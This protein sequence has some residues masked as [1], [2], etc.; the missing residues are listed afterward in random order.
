MVYEQRTYRNLVKAD[1]LIKFEVIDQETDLLILAEKDL[2]EKAL[3]LVKQY[4]QELETFMKKDQIFGKTF[5]PHKVD[6]KAPA[7]AKRMAEAA[8]QAK[9]GPMAAVA[10][11][12]AEAV[13]KD[14]LHFTDQ[15]IIENGGD[16]FLKI[17]GIKKVGIFAGNSPF[18]GKI[19]LEIEPRLKP[20]A[21]CT[22]SGTVGHSFSFGKADAVVVIAENACLADAAATAIANVVVEATDI[23]RAL[24][25]AKKIKGLDG[26]L[27]IKGDQMG[28]LGKLKL[29]PA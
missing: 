6:K 27:V 5:S 29:V 1:N 14:L 17:T 16:I 13:G 7:I 11:A 19:A 23:N 25:I 10:G 15:I 28:A 9:V 2:Q 26:V 4:R 18:T 21:I 22:S 12:M 24:A 20:F 8:R 3:E